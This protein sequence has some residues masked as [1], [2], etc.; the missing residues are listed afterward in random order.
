MR[1][2][3]RGESEGEPIGK[4]FFRTQ[5]ME[6]DRPSV[7]Q[8]RECDVEIGSGVEVAHEDPIRDAPRGNVTAIAV[9]RHDVVR[10]VQPNVA[11]EVGIA[12]GIEL[13]GVHDLGSGAFRDGQREVSDPREQVHDDRARGDSPRDADPLREVA[14]REHDLGHVQRITHAGLDV[15]GLGPVPPQ[16]VDVR[17]PEG[18]M[19][20]RPVLDNR[21]GTEHRPVDSRDL[22]RM[23]PRPRAEA[24]DDHI[25]DSLPSSR[26]DGDGDRRGRQ[27]LAYVIPWVPRSSPRRDVSGFLKL[28]ADRGPVEGR[29]LDDGHEHAS[30][31]LHNLPRSIDEPARPEGLEKLECLRRRHGEDSRTLPA[32]SVHVQFDGGYAPRYVYEVQSSSSRPMRALAVALSLLLLAV[33][34]VPTAR[35][36]D[37]GAVGKV[38]SLIRV[39]ATPQLAPGESGRFEFFF[40]STYA[41]P[42]QNVRLNASIYQYA[43]IEESIPVD[44]VWPYRYP[45]IAEGSSPSGREWVW[46]API[47]EPSASNLLNFTVV[48]AASSNDMPH[49]SVFSQ[50]SYFIRFWLEFDGTSDGNTTRYRMASLGFFSR[51]LWE[52]AT[53]ENATNP[54]RPPWCRG[55]NTNIS[56]LGVDGVLPD[57]AFGV[58]EPIPRW[59]FYALIAAAALFLVLAFLFWVDENPAEFPRVAAWWARQKGRMTRKSSGLRPKR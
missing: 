5:L 23:G 40:N 56:I 37:F 44:H 50:A 49:G 21:E 16:D 29:V 12:H 17:R 24:E 42:I 43:T 53:S 31:P 59:P 15:L 48:T 20:S 26:R 6:D 39:V 57:S 7:P 2:S 52:R 35:G 58:K 1:S 3:G 33:P 22:R 13:A 28:R 18:P 41:E 8:G 30:R 47:V 54:C 36:E 11:D 32:G 4:L 10:P 9:E 27:T 38:S 55:D 46:T 34:L 45:R 14:G 19:D 25:P 51:Q